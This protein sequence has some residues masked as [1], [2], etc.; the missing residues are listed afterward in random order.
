MANFAL[1]RYIQLARGV[2]E[3]HDRLEPYVRRTPLE[4]SRLLEAE[5]G[6]AA[7]GLKLESLQHTGSFKLR[8]AL[9]RL[10]TLSETRRRRGVIAA[11]SGN[12]GLAVARSL[13]ILGCPGTIYLPRNAAGQKVE[14]L[15]RSGVT[16][17][18]FGKDCVEAEHR[19][20][21]VAA[22]RG[23]FY[24]SP[25][26]DPEVIAGQGTVGLEILEQA[27][28]VEVVFVAVGGGGLISGVAGWMKSRNPRIEIVGCVPE[29]SPVMARSVAAERIVDVPVGPTLSDG[30][31]GGIEEGAIT[32][33]PCRRLVDRWIEVD[34]E[35]IA[36]AMLLVLDR[37]HLVIEGAA[38]VAVAALRQERQRC[39]GRN[40]AVVLCGGNVAATTLR[41][42]LESR[43]A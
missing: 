13:E 28:G 11:S 26:N 15:G 1:A 3:A 17:E 6:A 5:T 18:I 30:T 24:V 22:E 43:L 42:I 14:D 19:A 40:V 20:R 27:P 9:N 16:V 32:L 37:H 7:V 31:A 38:G 35:A 29:R 23:L 34:E 39:A 36:D 33:D 21:E 41:S 25:Y 4:R 10:L 8:G 12:H 2:G